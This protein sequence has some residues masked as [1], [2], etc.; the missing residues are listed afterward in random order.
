LVVKGGSLFARLPL[1]GGAI[2]FESCV[3]LQVPSPPFLCD[4]RYR[5]SVIGYR[6]FGT[7]YQPCPQQTRIY[8]NLKDS[9]KGN[10]K[11]VP[12]Q[13]WTGPEGSRKLKFPDFRDNGTGLW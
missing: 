2:E 8:M 9:K 7:K 6:Y 5:R 4:V 11:A 3:E 13:A 1:P 12:L 10:G